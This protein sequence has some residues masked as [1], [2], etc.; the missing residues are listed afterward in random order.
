MPT[1]TLSAR[2]KNGWFD[3]TIEP[4]S[5][6]PQAMIDCKALWDKRGRRR[7]WPK[8]QWAFVR[9]AIQPMLHGTIDPEDEHYD[10][11][12]LNPRGTIHSQSVELTSVSFVKGSI[13]TVSV[14]AYFELS[15]DKQFKDSWEFSDWQE[16]TD[17]M[18][19]CT[20]FGWLFPCGNGY[21]AGEENAG[22]ELQ[23]LI[24]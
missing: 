7:S 4:D 13:P 15:F 17:R 11:G 1:Y 21:D 16:A 6:I 18:E 5:I 3:H 14:Y 12:L 10:G 19:W 20:N 24:P 22:I 23:L 8:D 2:L 9:A